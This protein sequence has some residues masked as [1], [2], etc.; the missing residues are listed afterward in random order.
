[1][2]GREAR[3]SAYGPRGGGPAIA[4]VN[5]DRLTTFG[6]RRMVVPFADRVSVV[7]QMAT[8][9]LVLVDPQLTTPAEADVIHLLDTLPAGV[10]AYTWA[11]ATG[12]AGPTRL[13]SAG[14]PL[15]G[16]LS[17]G[18]TADALVL[19]IERIHDGEWVSLDA[20]PPMALRPRPCAPSTWVCLSPRE[21]RSSP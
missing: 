4:L 20:P 14:W 16:W 1:M 6:L 5:G 3:G 9:D 8:A 7:D 12:P 2:S 11:P 19:A 10:V 21:T 18:L 13:R 17:K 15:R